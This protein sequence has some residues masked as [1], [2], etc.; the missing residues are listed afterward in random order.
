MCWKDQA[1]PVAGACAGITGIEFN[2]DAQI[3]YLLHPADSS[4]VRNKVWVENLPLL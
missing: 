4:V 2:A 3:P 1:D